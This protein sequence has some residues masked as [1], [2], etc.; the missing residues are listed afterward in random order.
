M[1]HPLTRYRES[2]EPVLSK[3][4][5]ADRL[6]VGRAAITRWESNQR[7]IRATLVPKISSV[8]GIPAKEL[9]PDLEEIFGEAQ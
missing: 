7:K 9:R 1:D 4:E 3:A 8:T 5:L 6:G 2:Q